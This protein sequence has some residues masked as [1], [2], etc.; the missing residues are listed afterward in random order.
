MKAGM[1]GD[2]RL[3]EWL[4]VVQLSYSYAVA[5]GSPALTWQVGV[6][7]RMMIRASYW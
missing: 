1:S 7:V 2:G 5:T 3:K 4:P 6:R